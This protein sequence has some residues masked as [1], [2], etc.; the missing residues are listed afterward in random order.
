MSER[1]T[2]RQT[3]RIG[4]AERIRRVRPLQYQGAQRAGE[5]RVVPRVPQMAGNSL[6]EARQPSIVTEMDG[7][8]RQTGVI[9]ITT[10]VSSGRLGWRMRWTRR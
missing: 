1:A 8:L 7:R 9:A 3:S 6:S 5:L 4:W 10:G 2:M